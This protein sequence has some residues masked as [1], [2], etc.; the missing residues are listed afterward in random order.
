MKSRKFL[1]SHQNTLK[2]QQQQQKTTNKARCLGPTAS[3]MLHPVNISYNY[4]QKV[5]YY[6]FY[7]PQEPVL[8]F[9]AWQ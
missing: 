1:F 9:S 7:K 4:N 3:V 5:A 8:R 6:S 2:Q